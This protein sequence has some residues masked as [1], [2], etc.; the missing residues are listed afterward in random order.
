MRYESAWAT[1]CPSYRTLFVFGVVSLLV[2]GA[3]VVK[4]AGQSQNW[5]VNP[6]FEEADGKRPASWR[7]EGWG[8]R[9]DFTYAE[10][11]RTGN[12]SV[13]ISSTSGADIGWSQDV[14]VRPFCRYKL[15]GWIKTENL[16]ADSARGALFNLHN[17]QSARSGAVKGTSDWT[18]VE[19]NFQTD[20]H[21]TVQVNCLFGGWG[22]ATGKAGFDDLNL[23]LVATDVESRRRPKMYYTDDSRGRAFAKD[24]DVAR[25]GGRYL[26]Y[27]TIS[28][29]RKGI[30][31]G[32]AESSNLNDW[33][34]V[35]EVLPEADYE[36]NGI[37][38]PG[39]FVRDGKLHLFYQTYGNREKDA[40]CHAWSDDGIN[41][42]RNPTNPIFRPTGDWNCGRAIDADV[43]EFKGS[44]LLYCATRDPSYRIQ[45]VV[46]ASSPVGSGFRRESWKQLGDGPALEPEL[47]WEKKCIEASSVC[48]HNG[49]LYMFYAG[50]YNNEPQQI[51]CAVSTDGVGWKRL[52]ELPL[53]PNGKANEWNSSESG[54][55][56]VFVDDDGKTYLFFQGNNNKGKTWFLSNM[57]VKWDGDMP[58]LVRQRDNHVFRIRETVKP[59]ITIDPAKTKEP[60]SQFVYGQF[61]EHLGRCIYGGIWAEMLEDRKFYFPVTAEYEPYR[62]GGVTKERPFPV[63]AASPWQIVG[64]ADS[65]RMVKEDSFVGEHTPLIKEGG[66]I[67]QLDLGLLKNK[68]CRGYIWL[69][70]EKRGADVT[71]SLVWGDGR[72][73]RDTVSL[74]A[75]GREYKKHE[76][77]FTAGADT[78]QGKLEIKVSGGSCYVGTISLMPAD[79]IEG[80]RP[81]TMKLLKELNAPLYRWPGGN[82]VSGYDWR[83]GIGDRD[84]RPPR[85][86]PAWTGVEHNDFGF[87]E[88]IHFCRMLHAEPLV[89]VN[90]GFGDAYSAAAQLEYSNGSTDT[91]WGRQRNDNGTPEPFGVK[92]WCIGNEMFG[93]WQLGYMKMEHYV[94]KHN[95]VVDIMRKVD[96]DIVEI[97]SGNAG[98]WSEGLLKNCPDHIELI[99]EHFYCQE[100]ADLADHTS[101]IA[102]QIRRKV[103]FHRNLRN[104]LDALEGKDI[105]IAM[106]EWNYWYGPHVFGELGTRYFLKDALG[107]ARGL[108]EYFRNSNIVYMANYAQTVNVIGCIKASKTHAAMAAT[109]Q[110]LTLYRNHFGQIP[111]EVS[112]DFDELDVSAA[113][114][115]DRRRLT[116]AIV[117]P[118]Y[119][120]YE[121]SL[122]LEQERSLSCRRSWQITGPDEGAFNEPGKPERIR[123]EERT[124]DADM[125]KIQIS[126]IS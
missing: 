27:Y 73:K 34:K 65:V 55:P 53:L 16:R 125:S 1:S 106:T 57:L 107:I 105:R 54:H 30:A 108:H 13:M 81:D 78:T 44:F 60:I 4:A 56:G 7:T 47:F 38:A 82:F 6:S 96:P 51:G 117:N 12:R 89:T 109:G 119:Q 122:N 74:N 59:S 66:G 2:S 21:T 75:A 123:I 26:M 84:R 86:N 8:G 3:V 11:G 43:I 92:F 124:A 31:I 95:W 101:Q 25:F 28:R 116:V 115:E 18:Q 91:Y 15:T 20:T 121:V 100:R 48:E 72:R 79:N 39:A 126:P 9:G 52:S 85:M 114:S 93:S 17:I 102:E 69:K 97:A 120:K 110:V 33:K 36:K 76:L 45:K 77:R 14:G 24:P 50:G 104:R 62:G 35:G 64:P 90:T 103:D 111:V 98:P 70:P 58:Y 49:K 32:I 61:I 29:P 67:R 71:I 118:T 23:Q 99:A 94:Q 19:M 37:G 83:D 88:F 46:A 42:T 113:L 22:Q 5:I 68:E 41:F 112:G 10:S 87:D 40:I 63:V 80:T